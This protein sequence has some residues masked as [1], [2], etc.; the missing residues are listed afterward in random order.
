MD[1]RQPN[2]VLFLSVHPEFAARILNGTKTIELRRVRP[3]LNM[4]SPVVVYATSPVSSVVGVFTLGQMIV[5]HPDALWREHSERT[6]IT[7]TTFAA[8]F[9]GTDRAIGLEVADVRAFSKPL[10]LAE[11]RDHWPEFWPPVS[12]RYFVGRRTAKALHLEWLGRTISLPVATAGF[13]HQ[14]I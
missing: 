14:T 12:F 3:R 11:M 5:A 10:T 9:R 13:E 8:Y 2:E 7:L 6:G 1:S 4:G